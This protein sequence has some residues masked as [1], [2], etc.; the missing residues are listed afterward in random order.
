MDRFSATP[1][2]SSIGGPRYAAAVDDILYVDRFERQGSQTKPTTGEADS[3][4]SVS[5]ILKGRY[6]ASGHHQ[7]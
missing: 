3:R 5:M 6:S 1:L 7:G 2:L 4:R